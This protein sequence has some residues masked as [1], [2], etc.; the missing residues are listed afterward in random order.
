[1]FKRFLSFCCCL[2]VLCNLLVVSG[3]A[4]AAESVETVTNEDLLEAIENLQADPSEDVQA[5]D[6][7]VTP[8]DD[9]SL[10]VSDEVGFDS[11]P[12][13]SFSTYADVEVEFVDEP[14]SDPPFY[15][16]LYV[17][18]ELTS[19][20]TVT[21]YFPTNYQ[22]GYFGLDSNG[23]LFNVSSNS[24]SGYYEGVHNNSVSLPSFSY[25][26]YRETSSYDYITMYM[27]PIATNI[28]IATAF[29]PV[30]SAADILPYVIILCLGVLIV[31]YMKR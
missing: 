9:L 27:K 4:T 8:Q 11:V 22:S 3:F 20:E 21:W 12:D 29:E 24:I 23:Y 1:M 16:A 7:T 5:S 17:T 25:P 18:G 10:A 19:G 14:P 6:Q 28:D 13:L 30:V 31:C 15:G 26:R 2:V